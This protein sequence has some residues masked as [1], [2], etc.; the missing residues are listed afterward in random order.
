MS[1]DSEK[2]VPTV[3]GM[4]RLRVLPGRGADSNAQPQPKTHVRR[5]F[6]VPPW[7]VRAAEAWSQGRLLGYQPRARAQT[8]AGPDGAEH[9]PA[10]ESGEDRTKPRVPLILL[11]GVAFGLVIVGTALAFTFLSRAEG[12]TIMPASA[13]PAEKSVS[14]A[15]TR[16]PST[17]PQP[18]LQPPSARASGNLEMMQAPEPTRSAVPMV[19]AAA[20]STKPQPGKPSPPQRNNQDAARSHSTPPG[21]SLESPY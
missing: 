1:S 10:S 8:A 12:S 13:K 18:D 17:A 7:L 21:I 5:T 11:G 3:P 20:T 16:P 19:T 15:P 2:D 6:T 9:A 4:R 14:L